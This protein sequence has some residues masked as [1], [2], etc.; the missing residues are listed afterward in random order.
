M[1]KFDEF[2]QEMMDNYFNEIGYK[3]NSYPLIKEIIL[4]E[5]FKTTNIW[6][7]DITSTKKKKVGQYIYVHYDSEGNIWNFGETK[8]IQRLNNYHCCTFN[9][10]YSFKETAKS[11]GKGNVSKNIW[12]VN[13]VLSK[14]KTL[15]VHIYEFLPEFGGPK[16]R[17]Y[18]PPPQ[19][20]EIK[21]FCKKKFNKLPEW[22][23]RNIEKNLW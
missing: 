20:G 10:D 17:P 3:F 16:N 12:M 8:N 19:E 22:I 23:T 21:E 13:D 11:N 5:D 2:H 14:G 6:E 7:K 15:K 1:L 9:P 4:T 18:F